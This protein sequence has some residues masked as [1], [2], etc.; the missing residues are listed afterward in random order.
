MTLFIV[1]SN[2]LAES[3]GWSKSDPA[4]LAGL[5]ARLGVE[6][7]TLDRG[8]V[9][10]GLRSQTPG[11]N[12]GRGMEAGE[13][14]CASPRGAARESRPAPRSDWRR[15][16]A[17]AHHLSVRAPRGPATKPARR[18]R[19]LSDALI[20]APAPIGAA[21]ALAR[22]RSTRETRAGSCAPTRTPSRP[23]RDE[24][25]GARE[26]AQGVCLIRG[27]RRLPARRRL[28]SASG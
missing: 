6:G 5:C 21:A 12:E 25:A 10:S 15:Q 11:R 18:R 27:Q 2:A 23:R 13:G 14:L 9:G 26:A 1:C 20:V 16:G 28:W 7:P 19:D 3:R 22:S 4:R 17:Q 24:R 8:G